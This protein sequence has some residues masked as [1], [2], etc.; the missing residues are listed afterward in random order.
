MLLGLLQNTHRLH[1]FVTE[2]VKESRGTFMFKGP[3]FANMDMLLTSDTAN[4]QHIFSKNFSNYP[5]GI[6]FNRAFDILENG[7]INADSEFWKT[8]RKTTMSL[9]N[10][11]WF[12]KF[13]AK[14]S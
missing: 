13:V 4:I 9:F 6:E 2:V 7:I 1:K 14:T 5:K 3:W 12:Q 11:H 8:Q 10:Q